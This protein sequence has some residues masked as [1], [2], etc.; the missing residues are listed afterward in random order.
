MS[1]KQVLG[2]ALLAVVGAAYLGLSYAITVAEHPTLAMLVFSIAPLAA[3]ALASAWHARARGLALGLCAIATAA[4]LLNL[5]WLRAHTAWLYF[6]QHFGAMALLGLNFGRTLGQGDANALCSRITT[7]ILRTE[8]DP[9]YMHYTWKVT[10]AW[11]VYFACSALLSVLLFFGAPIE[12]WS[13]FANVL[14]PL[15]IGAMF[16]V[17]YLIRVRTMPQRVH[18]SIAETIRAYRKH[19]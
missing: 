2:L 17:E 12:A 6:L 16:M 5:D 11:T 9:K 14:T 7:L 8:V 19:A 13:V 10:L 18:F 3:M 15:L 1:P 4:V